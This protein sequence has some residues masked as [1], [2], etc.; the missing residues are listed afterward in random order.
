M[1]GAGFNLVLFE[2]SVCVCVCVHTSVHVDACV[3][4]MCGF[5]RRLY[6]GEGVI[7]NEREKKSQRQNSLNNNV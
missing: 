6:V 4:C 2:G 1:R 3:H 7:I 5:M